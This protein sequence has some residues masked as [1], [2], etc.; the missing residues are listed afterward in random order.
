MTSL[1][2]YKFTIIAHHPQSPG[3]NTSCSPPLPRDE[4]TPPE[5]CQAAAAAPRAAAGFKTTT[6]P[7][8]HRHG[9]KSPGSGADDRHSTAP[10]RFNEAANHSLLVHQAVR[11]ELLPTQGALGLRDGDQQ[12]SAGRGG[13]VPPL[14]QAEDAAGGAG[15][16]WA[17]ALRTGD[18]PEVS[19]D[20]RLT[21]FHSNRDL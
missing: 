21:G 3:W 9:R 2:G 12:V 19:A 6:R 17:S 8:I 1:P 10:R 16:G 4:N 7:D 14:L 20:A 13:G 18:T 15:S 11:L 5:R